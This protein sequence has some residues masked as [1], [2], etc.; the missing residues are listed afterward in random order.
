LEINARA[1]LEVQ[2]VSDTKLKNI[3]DKIED[4]KIIDPE[5]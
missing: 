4:L 3:L 1:G 5:K 2:K